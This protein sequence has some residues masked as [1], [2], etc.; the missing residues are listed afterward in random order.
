MALPFTPSFVDLRRRADGTFPVNPFVA[1]NPL[2]TAA[3]MKNDETV[4]RS[5]A[6]GRLTFD[7]FQSPT[8]HLRVQAALAE[9][10]SNAYGLLDLWQHGAIGSFE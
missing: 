9:Q 5:I 7:L 1:S 4:W 2:Q 3:L 10:L 6:A 8:Q